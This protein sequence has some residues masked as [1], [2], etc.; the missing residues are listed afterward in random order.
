[1]PHSEH[2]LGMLWFSSVVECFCEHVRMKALA[3]LLATAYR[4]SL[5]MV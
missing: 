5:V 2:L 4:F 3:S 1:M